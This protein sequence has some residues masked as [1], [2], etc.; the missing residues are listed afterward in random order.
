MNSKPRALRS[1]LL[2]AVVS[3]CSLGIVA[4]FGSVA[5]TPSNVVPITSEPD[6]KIRFDNGTVR[7]YEVLLPKGKGTLVHEHRADSFS[8]IFGDSE[9][10]NE[11]LGGKPATVKIP[12]GAVGFASTEKGPYAHRVIASGDSAFHVIAM[13]LMSPKPAG[14]ASASQRVDPPFKVVRENPRGRVYRIRLAPG[15][16]T[17]MF[18]RP[19]S[20]AL[21]AIS[22]GRI[23]EDVDGK[24]NR[25]WDF[26]T[27]HFRWI[28]VPERL[29][30]KNEGTAPIDLVEIEV[31]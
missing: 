16:S 11:P 19:G 27:G 4:S 30:V 21:F 1:Y 2:I 15:E 13:E 20:T 23:R 5:Q 10:T 28:E 26:E 9:I 14:P 25:L 24:A 17:G 8:I 12:S 22:S 29:S 18:A 31:F 3:S 7:M 6:H